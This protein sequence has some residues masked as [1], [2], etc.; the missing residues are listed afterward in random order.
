MDRFNCHNFESFHVS[1]PSVYYLR[2]PA[3]LL[4]DGVLRQNDSKTSLHTSLMT[5]L[6]NERI[7][8]PPPIMTKTSYFSIPSQHLFLSHFFHNS[9]SLIFG[10]PLSLFWFPLPLHSQWQTLKSLL[11]ALLHP[12]GDTTRHADL[13]HTRLRY[14][15]FV[16]TFLPTRLRPTI[17]SRGLL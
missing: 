11:P 16:P 1:L 12:M 14:L 13:P 3:A 15:T 9:S 8:S 6:R 7:S 2:I 17:V 4:T 10:R 5:M